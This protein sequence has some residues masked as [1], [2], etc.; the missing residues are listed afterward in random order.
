MSPSNSLWLQ[1]IPHNGS[2]GLA[3]R[4]LTFFSEIH[5]KFVRQMETCFVWER[6]HELQS[7]MT[8]CAPHHLVPSYIFFPHLRRRTRGGKNFLNITELQQHRSV[9]TVL[10]KPRRR[11]P[12]PRNIASLYWNIDVSVWLVPHFCY[13]CENLA[14][15]PQFNAMGDIVIGTKL[16]WCLIEAIIFKKKTNNSFSSRLSYCSRFDIQTQL[17]YGEDSRRLVHGLR[18]DECGGTA[19]GVGLNAEAHLFEWTVQVTEWECSSTACW[20]NEAPL[21]RFL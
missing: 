1:R 4:L 15:S 6:L 14:W 9:H 10:C 13:Q 2:S 3:F 18:N 7:V 19:S 20:R 11:K 16:Q 8:H 17:R 21:H 12:L 5:L